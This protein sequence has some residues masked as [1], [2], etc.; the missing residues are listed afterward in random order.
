MLTK[1]LVLMFCM[2]YKLMMWYWIQIPKFS[3]WFN[4]I[5]YLPLIQIFYPI[6][7]ISTKLVMF[8][9]TILSLKYQYPIRANYAVLCSIPNIRIVRI[10]LWHI[11]LKFIGSVFI[12]PDTCTQ[13]LLK[14]FCRTY[15]NQTCGFSCLVGL[16]KVVAR[17]QVGNAYL[18]SVIFQFCCTNWVKG[19]YIVIYWIS[20]H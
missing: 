9:I 18:P 15:P 2:V 8:S 12:D 11:N 17:F 19:L 7:R 20:V 10:L 1:F 6:L 14:I 16:R 5:T 4:G 3:F 13:L